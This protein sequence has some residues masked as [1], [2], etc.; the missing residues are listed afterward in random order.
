MYFPDARETGVYGVCTALVVAFDVSLVG[1]GEACNVEAEVACDFETGDV[2][3]A[4]G[5]G[6]CD[7]ELACGDGDGDVC[8]EEVDG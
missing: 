2:G 6:G 1:F 8:E 5:G 3:E 4:A 7:E